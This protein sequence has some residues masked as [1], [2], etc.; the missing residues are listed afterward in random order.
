MV[1]NKGEYLGCLEP[2]IDDSI[3][4]DTQI[5]TQPDAHSTIS[6]TL[7]KMM[8]EQVQLDTFSPLCHKLRS[9]VKFKLDALV[10]EYASQFAKDKTSIG[11]TPLMEMT[12]H[13]ANS[14]PVF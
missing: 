7:Q 11:T 14:Y 2:A 9:S 10:K 1:S 3:T 12:I 8:A 13:M 6:I 5:H 4:S